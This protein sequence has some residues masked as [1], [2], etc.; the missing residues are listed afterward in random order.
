MGGW[1]GGQQKQNKGGERGGGV[2]G[3]AGLNHN[4]LPPLEIPVECNISTHRIKDIKKKIV[5]KKMLTV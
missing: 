4:P 1:G 5:A 2:R 3:G